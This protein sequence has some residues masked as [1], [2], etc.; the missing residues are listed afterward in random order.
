MVNNN[1]VAYGIEISK[2]EYIKAYSGEAE[3]YSCG[4][5]FRIDKSLDILE[6]TL[7]SSG[8]FRVSR[9]YIVNMSY[10]EAEKIKTDAISIGSEKI[11]ISRRRKKE[12]E[13]E[14]FKHNMEKHG[15]K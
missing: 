6:D 8:F 3:V 15:N 12:F 14:F 5:R 13:K 10:I 9:S 7:R 1:R 4:R 2:I 11:S